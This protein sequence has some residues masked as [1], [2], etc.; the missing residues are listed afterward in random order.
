MARPSVP[1]LS[2]DRIAR[3]ALALVDD[4]GIASLTIRALSERLGTTS[5]SLYNHVRDRDELLDLMIAAATE[6]IDPNPAEHPGLVDALV[7][8]ACSLLDAFGKHPNLAITIATRPVRSRASLEYYE[9]FLS[10]LDKAGA[11]PGE[12][13]N[14]VLAIDDYV[15]GALINSVQDIELGE[16]GEPGEYRLLEAALASPA[17]RDR[18][19]NLRA[20]VVGLT[21][22]LRLAG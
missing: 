1:L 10:R 14:I 13:L 9:R 3:T 8:Q 16:S 15:L 12:A 22:G 18:E 20:L 5:S 7:A 6:E 19:T 11:T 21:A 17:N 4:A 2:K